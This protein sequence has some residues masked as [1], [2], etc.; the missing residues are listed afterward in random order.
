LTGA[1]LGGLRTR[2]EFLFVQKGS[3]VA[4]TDLT[5][6]GRRRA[7]DGLVRFGVTASRKVGGAVERNRAKR[8]LRDIARGL[9]PLH[10]LPGADYVFVARATTPAAPWGRLLDDAQNALI[11][12]NRQ[13]AGASAPPSAPSTNDN[14]I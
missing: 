12:L 6:E 9:L 14:H 5:I 10:G 3:R 13:L 11:R 4:R 8:R 7:A 1:V 2:A